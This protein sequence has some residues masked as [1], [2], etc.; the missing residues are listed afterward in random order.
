[1]VSS[2]N[3]AAILA[4]PASQSGPRD[5]FVRAALMSG[6]S[7]DA[8]PSGVTMYKPEVMGKVS[9]LSDTQPKQPFSMSVARNP[10]S[11]GA[12]RRTGRVLKVYWSGPCRFFDDTITVQDIY[13]ANDAQV[14]YQGNKNDFP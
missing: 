7:V 3:K 9:S 13:F 8:L 5:M 11:Q 12:G 1:M 10:P 6:P 4:K 2:V 14:A